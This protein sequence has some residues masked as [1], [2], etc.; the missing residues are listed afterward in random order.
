MCGV[1]L[2]GSRYLN[3]RQR[4]TAWPW[5]IIEQAARAFEAYGNGSLGGE[6]LRQ[7]VT[8]AMEGLRRKNTSLM[9]V[10]E[11]RLARALEERRA[12]LEAGG[13]P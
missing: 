11:A 7:E 3:V 5:P 6:A 12:T 1:G 4:R 2:P 9:A 8:A 10:A 13:A